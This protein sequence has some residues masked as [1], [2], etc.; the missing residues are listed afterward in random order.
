MFSCSYFSTKL[1]IKFHAQFSFQTWYLYHC[2]F[3]SKFS[4]EFTQK[5]CVIC[6]SVLLVMHSCIMSVIHQICMDSSFQLCIRYAFSFWENLLYYNPHSYIHESASHA[7]DMH[8]QY[9]VLSFQ[10]SQSWTHVS[11]VYVLYVLHLI[12]SLLQLI[13]IRGRMFPRGR[14]YNTLYV[15]KLG[16]KRFFLRMKPPILWV[17]F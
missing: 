16:D 5:I 11:V 10:S 9:V 7:S 13:S 15:Y 2:I 6:L 17:A 1:G 4:H 3:M 12:N 14:Y 8:V